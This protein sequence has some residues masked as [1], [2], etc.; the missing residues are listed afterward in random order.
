M[1]LALER[2]FE[3]IGE[4]IARL[5]RIDHD[6]LANTIP[7][8]SKIIGFRYIISHGY[9]IIDH[10]TLWDFAKERIPEQLEQVHN[11]KS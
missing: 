7:E 11:Y 2:L 3:I 4:A 10:D 8:Y 9:D 5:D 6:N 1:Q